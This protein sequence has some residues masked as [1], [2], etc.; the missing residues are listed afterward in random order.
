M[1]FLADDLLEGRQ[2]GTRGYRIAAAYVA[3]ELERM[4][5]EPA[6]KDESFFQPVPLR[7]AALEADASSFTLRAG[8][9]SRRLRLGD[10]FV[11]TP[12]FDG[13]THRIDAGLVF[14]GFGVEAPELN[15]DDYA[16][17]DVSGK[18]VVVLSGAP[19]A[20]GSSERAFY[21]S[22]E[23]K[24][25]VALGHGASGLFMIQTPEDEAR[26]SWEEV[27]ERFAEPVLRWRDPES[28]LPQ[29][30]STRL[31]VAGMLSRDGA[32]ALLEGAPYG[33]SEIFDRAAAGDAPRFA[34]ASEASIAS[35]GTFEDFESVNVAGK[36]RGSDPTLESEHVIYSAHLDHVGMGE[37][38]D[39]DAI[40]NGAYDNA[41]GVAVVLAVAEA[42]MRRE[43]APRRSLLFLLVT[44]E[45]EGLLGSDYFA[46]YP[47][48]PKASIVAD[49]NVDGVLMFHPLKDVI[50]FG[51]DHS[52][53]AD[54]VS[55]AAAELGVAISPDFMPEEVIFIRS[56]QYSFVRQGI[57][58]VYA[59]V[60]VDTGD[61]RIDGEKVLRD[62]MTTIYH[63][64]TDDMT[65]EL[66]FEAGAHYARL[67]FGIGARVADADERPHWNEGD[68]LGEKFAISARR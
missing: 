8:A 12:A 9:S 54:P 2:P 1:S 11:L 62:W 61:S 33:L 5:L 45:E 23:N 35:A 44:A 66:D 24:A 60:G 52:T 48:V 15:H 21:S 27:R 3:S 25:E 18:L 68:F 30:P 43:P 14:A 17:L 57:P 53:L 42:F 49:I 56:D 29:A 67:V 39:G 22:R 28:G 36:L 20:F 46:R 31:A 32:N 41:S 51:A 38:V 26:I 34:L 40:Y 50:A 59:F 63:E 10:D 16:E 6:G 4:G 37:P 13:E 65:Q 19:S 55:K 7:R 64:P 58:S 47:T